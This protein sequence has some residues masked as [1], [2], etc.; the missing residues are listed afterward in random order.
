M[1]TPAAQELKNSLVTL[2]PIS[3]EEAA[4]YFEIGQDQ[5]IWHYLTPDPFHNVDDAGRWIKAMLQRS[6]TLG[7][8]TFSVYD[9]QTGKLAGSSSYLDVRVEH[10]GLE[11][12]FT[13]YGVAFQRTHVNTATKLVLMQ[14]AF[15]VL[16]ANRVQLQTDSRNLTS[17]RA[18]ERIG[19]VK[20]GVLR[21][22]KIYPD[23]YVRDS[24]MYS[25]TRSDWSGVKARLE[26]RLGL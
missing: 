21:Q 23:G 1:Q 3:E 7:D 6:S 24:V 20:E 13:W 2:K 9:N 18:I 19:G 10:G 4:A 17:Q 15:E 25:I 26:K 22:H 16:E 5:D 14:H 12:G 11:I 8:L